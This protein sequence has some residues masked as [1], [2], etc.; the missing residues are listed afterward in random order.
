MVGNL[1]LDFFVGR[2]EFLV[3][4]MTWAMPDLDKGLTGGLTHPTTV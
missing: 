3:S 4:A 2:R 1:L